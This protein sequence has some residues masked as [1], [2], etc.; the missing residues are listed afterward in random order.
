[1][2]VLLNG[3]A[4][5]HAAEGRREEVAAAFAKR[6]LDPLLEVVPAARMRRTVRRLVREGYRTLVAAGGDGTVATVADAIARTEATLGVLPL[7]TFNHFARDAGI[8]L[9]LDEA[10]DLACRG[11]TAFVDAASLN[12]RVFVNNAS[13]GVY[14]DQVRLRDRLR[15]RLGKW[16]AAAIGALSAMRRFRSLRMLVLAGEERL[17][18]RSPMLV[19]GNGDYGIEDG[20]PIRRPRL[21]AGVVSLY[22]F[23]SRSRLGLVMSALTGLAGHVDKVPSFTARRG[24]ELTIHLARRRVRVALDGEVVSLRTPLRI[25]SLPGALRVLVPPRPA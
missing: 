8:P 20:K 22:A 15:P 1:M 4:R 10:V 19:V 16:P 12:G 17:H 11:E 25:R 14:P 6:G 23:G 7:G 18:L 21:D 13:L 24:P 9:D 3:A 5:S 2:A